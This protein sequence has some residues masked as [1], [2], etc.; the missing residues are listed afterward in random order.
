MLMFKFTLKEVQITLRP[1]LLA[2]QEKTYEVK[3]R[4]VLKGKSVPHYAAVEP[5]GK[6]LMVASEK[7][8]VFTHVDD[9]P[10]EQPDPEPMEVGKTGGS[11]VLIQ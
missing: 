10:L 6:G 7:S 4:R 3:K 9:C 11:D 2:G 5:Q 1:W 8:F